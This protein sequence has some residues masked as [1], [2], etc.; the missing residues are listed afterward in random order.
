MHLVGWSKVRGAEPHPSA[1]LLR[2]TGLRDPSP[3]SKARKR[4]QGRIGKWMKGLSG[5]SPA[6]SQTKMLNGRGVCFDMELVLSHGLSEPAL[7]SPLLLHASD[8]R[9]ALVLVVFFPTKVAQII[10]L[11]IYLVHE[12][13][14]YEKENLCEKRRCLLCSPKSVLL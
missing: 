7:L 10:T 11:A 14:T 8:S 3:P 4:C 1:T 12:E 9:A 6:R 13:L 2:A 5:Q